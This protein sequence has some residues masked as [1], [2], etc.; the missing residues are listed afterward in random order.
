MRASGL[1]RQLITAV[2]ALATALA[3]GAV[4]CAEAELEPPEIQ[5]NNNDGSDNQ[6]N[7]G[8]LEDCTEDEDCPDGEECVF[9]DSEDEGGECRTAV[10]P[11]NGSEG[12]A[13]EDDSDCETGSCEDGVCVSGCDDED[14]CPEGFACGD[15]GYCEAPGCSADSDCASGQA[16]S[17]VVDDEGDGL[18]TRC[19]GGDDGADPG[20]D[21]DDH[22]D[23]RGRY[24][25][26]G[27][28]TSPCINDDDCGTNQSCEP[29][30]AEID[31]VGDELDLCVS[32]EVQF[33]ESPEDCEDDN[34]TCNMP[35]YGADGEIDGGSC[36]FANPGEGDVGESCAANSECESNLCRA[37]ADQSVGECTVFCEESERDCGSGQRC[38]HAAEELGFCAGGCARDA[39]CDG[40][41]VCVLGLDREG[42]LH[43]FCDPPS[44]DA[45]GMTGDD[46]D[47][48]SE[49]KTG[50]CLTSAF[51]GECIGDE[52]CPD[53]TECG[54][55]PTDPGCSEHICYRSFCSEVCDPANG[56]ADCESPDHD[57]DRCADDVT[58]EVDGGIQ[59]ASMCAM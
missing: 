12:D 30:P 22:E 42:S 58:I 44:D 51:E 24:C 11:P 27:E 8:S 19:R 41:D 52:Q 33:C 15:D 37:S 10:D 2:V 54:C 18:E 34:M 21:C 7:N 16:C 45:V 50:I 36:G 55:P 38:V 3:V 5:A 49:C 23:C 56:D 31:E 9:E 53:G 32:M 48:D 40:G 4:G 46:C 1:R 25:R 6:S 26:Q 13:C 35:T 28:C 29:T 47:S 39:D 17:V 59:E 14:D 43:T 20:A 57:I